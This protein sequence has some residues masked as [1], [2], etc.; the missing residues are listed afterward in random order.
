MITLNVFALT[1]ARAI[2]GTG[3]AGTVPGDCVA[4]L[5]VNGMRLSR[6]ARVRAL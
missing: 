6:G 3:R 2:I 1:P 4:L 5:P